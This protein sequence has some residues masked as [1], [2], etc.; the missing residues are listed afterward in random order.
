M[1]RYLARYAALAA[2]VCLLGSPL[3]AQTPVKIGVFDAQRISEETAE[4]KRIHAQLNAFR[5]QKQKELS[6]K[7]QELTELQ[8]RLTSQAL[9]L[10]QEKRAALEKEIQRKV[11]ELNQAREAATREMQLELTEAQELFQEK[12]LAVVR[13][14][15]AD[16]GFAV[17]LE[18]SLVAYYDPTV[19]VT[20]AL[21]ERFNQAYPV[22]DEKEGAGKGGS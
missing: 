11:L 2:A 19:D 18:S 21:I 20:G 6:A 5:E 15:G 10:S 8:N 17:L 22:A 12:L 13:Q 7:E 4:G 1:A 14:F 9:S 3:A 16:E